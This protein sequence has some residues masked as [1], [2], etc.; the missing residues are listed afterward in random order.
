MGHTYRRWDTHEEW[1]TQEE[2]TQEEGYNIFTG[3]GIYGTGGN[4]YKRRNMHMGRIRSDGVHTRD[5]IE[6]KSTQATK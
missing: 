2:D 6:T 3:T 1:N 4:T 5:E